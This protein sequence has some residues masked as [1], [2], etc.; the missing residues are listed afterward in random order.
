MLNPPPSYLDLF[1]GRCR[2]S[3]VLY[4]RVRG[5]ALVLTDEVVYWA[6]KVLRACT[7]LVQGRSK[8]KR[9]R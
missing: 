2:V 6:L 3:R 4:G 8:D 5:L 1:L 9:S 7:Q